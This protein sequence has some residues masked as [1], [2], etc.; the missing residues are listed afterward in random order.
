MSKE[1]EDLVALRGWAE[2]VVNLE[3]GEQVVQL[4]NKAMLVGVEMG[5][6]AGTKPYMRKS[7]A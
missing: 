7:I 6:W 2:L 5:V 3:W 4:A 1:L